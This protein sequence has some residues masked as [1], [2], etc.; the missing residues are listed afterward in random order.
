MDKRDRALDLAAAIEKIGAY[1]VD[2]Q[3]ENEER[4]WSYYTWAYY[5]EETESF[6]L[7]TGDE[8][9]SLAS[10]YELDVDQWAENTAST[11]IEYGKRPPRR[12]A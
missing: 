11:A 1:R 6:W 10:E 9:V 8:L 3:L 7:V 2:R 12:A 5:A 4:E